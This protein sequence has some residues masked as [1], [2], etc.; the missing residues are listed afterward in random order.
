MKNKYH[1]VLNLNSLCWESKPVSLFDD[2]DVCK[3]RIEAGTYV[4]EISTD[5]K[6]QSQSEAEKIGVEKIIN[7]L[8]TRPSVRKT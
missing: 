5:V 3:V 4:M 6:A 2:F 7:F 1:I 8:L